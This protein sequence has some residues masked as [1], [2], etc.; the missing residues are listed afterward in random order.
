MDYYHVINRGVEK[1]DVFLANGDYVRFIHDMYVF[2][3][4]KSA[5][6]YVVKERQGERKRDLLVHIHAF[7]LMPNHYH[8]L[9]SP[10]KENG[11]SL[12]MKKVNM[13][14]AKYFNE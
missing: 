2:N 7:C 3:D 4:V 1:R 14:Y 12:F 5:P 10:I 6:N 8:I 11:M 9:L 13:G